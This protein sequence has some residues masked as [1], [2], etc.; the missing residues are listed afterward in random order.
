M[1]KLLLGLTTLCS[2]SMNA[3]LISF[4]P[5]DSASVTQTIT[6]G[7]DVVE[8]FLSAENTTNMSKSLKWSKAELTIPKEWGNFQVC[9]PGH[10]WGSDAFTIPH[11]YT[12]G[13][14]ATGIFKIDLNTYCVPGSGKVR[15]KT[16]ETADS[17]NTLQ[18]ITFLFDVTASANCVN[19]AIN[20]F[21]TE[22]LRFYP[23]PVKDQLKI[24]GL[25]DAKNARIELFNVIGSKLM[26]KTLELSSADEAELNTETLDQGVYFVKLYSNNKLIATK[27]FSKE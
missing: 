22:N 24:T 10:C 25:T 14:N 15:L 21:K 1:K 5:N 23:N 20:D 8:V 26:T 16:W 13:A 17:A 12:L 7:S 18:Y 27:K 3:Q 9:D 11:S 19:T 6:N 4:T 2:L